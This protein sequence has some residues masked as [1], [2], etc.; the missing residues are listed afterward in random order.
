MTTQVYWSPKPGAAATGAVK[1][2][3]KGWARFANP[4]TL[5]RITQFGFFAFIAFIAVR[6][7]LVGEG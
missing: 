6:H 7:I 4:Q 2:R 3:R 5:R 1:A